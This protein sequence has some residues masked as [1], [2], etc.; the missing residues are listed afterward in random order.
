[1]LRTQESLVTEAAVRAAEL[2]KSVMSIDPVKAETVLNDLF[3]LRHDLQ[4]IRTNAAQTHELYVHLIDTL[5][6]QEGL[7]K[8]DI[9]RLTTSAWASATCGTPPISSANTCRRCS[10]C[11][12]PR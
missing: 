12:R 2:E 7:M 1:M 3:S 10:T 5:D 9:R 8:L 11:C 6:S 4:T